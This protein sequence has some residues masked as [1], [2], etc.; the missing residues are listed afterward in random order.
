VELPIA[1]VFEGLGRTDSFSYR[2]RD[3]YGQL[4]RA[5]EE[6]ETDLTP[7]AVMATDRDRESLI[8]STMRVLIALAPTS[9]DPFAPKPWETI[10]EQSHHAIQ[11]AFV[12]RHRL[13]QEEELARQQ[14]GDKKEGESWQP[15]TGPVGTFRI[16]RNR[17]FQLTKVLD[18]LV[19]LAQSDMAKVANR[20]ALLLIGNAGIGK[21]HLFSDV[22]R[23]R[24]E[25]G[26]PTVFLLGQDFFRDE[27]WAQILRRLHLQCSRDE[28]LGALDAVAQATGRRALIF[29]D[30]LNDG[31]GRYLWE[32]H[33]PSVLAVLHRYP[34]LGLAV[35]CRSSYEKV[36]IRDDLM[37][38]YF[39]L[40][41]AD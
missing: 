20:P 36:I 40:R 37:P 39:P 31:E 28:F 2:L 17:L 6:L 21:T 1:E 16:L 33:L 38:L 8:Q 7:E 30:A 18:R 3:L 24:V 14:H 26:L 11:A 10:C 13:E 29:I 32:N 41:I 9:E 34:R 25:H 23:V 4:R 22:V 27:P 5:L 12:C 15:Q 35:S 19:I